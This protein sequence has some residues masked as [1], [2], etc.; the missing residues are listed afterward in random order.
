MN[1]A[2][3]RVDVGVVHDL[4]IVPETC[5]SLCCSC[6]ERV[7]AHAMKWDV[8]YSRIL[9][10][11]PPRRLYALSGLSWF[12]VLE[13]V[14]RWPCIFAEPLKDESYLRVNWHCS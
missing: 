5:P 12:R 3:R 2:H 4:L 10:G 6:P 14:T 8:R 1:V 13:Q 11:R 7:T 9:K